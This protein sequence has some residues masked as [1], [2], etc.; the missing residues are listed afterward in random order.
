MWEK[1]LQEPTSEKKKHNLK[2]H[3][4]LVHTKY[5]VITKEYLAT[6]STVN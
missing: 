3:T 2:L 4:P 1:M 6:F 5:I